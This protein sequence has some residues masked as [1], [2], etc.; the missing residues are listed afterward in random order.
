VPRLVRGQSQQSCLEHAAAHAPNTPHQ[1]LLVTKDQENTCWHRIEESFLKGEVPRLG[2]QRRI[3]DPD[4]NTLH[5]PGWRPHYRRE[6]RCHCLCAQGRREARYEFD[7]RL[8][9]LNVGRKIDYL[10]RSGRWGAS[11]IYMASLLERLGIGAEMKPKTKLSPSA[12]LL[13]ASVANGDVEIGFNQIS[14]VLA[15]PSVEFASP[16]A[17]RDSELYPVR[18]WAS[19]PAP[20]WLTPQRRWSLSLPR[21][22]PRRF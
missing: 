2:M 8:Q 16:A 14:E 4:N 13:Y 15:P 12:N 3:T 22:P 9:T 17:L 6:G 1:C 11:G 10:S 19:L 20:M 7:R 18:P 21:L 5:L